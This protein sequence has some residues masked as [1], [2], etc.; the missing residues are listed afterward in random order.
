YADDLLAQPIEII[1]GCARVPEAPGLGIAVDET[2]LA[3]YRMDPPYALPKPRLL[4]EVIWPNDHR[5]FYAD[6]GQVWADAQHGNI[7]AQARGVRMVTHADDGSREWADLF[8]RAQA[9]PVIARV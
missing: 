2:A 3:K 4:L 1:G 8:T 5:R 9:G 7:P 6:I